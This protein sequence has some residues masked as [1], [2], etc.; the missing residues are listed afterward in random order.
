MDAEHGARDDRRLDRGGEERVGQPDRLDLFEG[1]FVRALLPQDHV[2][3]E[4]V[5]L[6]TLHQATNLLLRELG[7]DVEQC[8]RVERAVPE[9]LE[10]VGRGRGADEVI[11]TPSPR[12]DATLPVA[13]E[14]AAGFGDDVH[15][16]YG[17]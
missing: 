14:D 6:S 4:T 1:D 17:H 2:W 3:D 11:T 10:R 12:R 5:G 8:D 9:P 13:F 7:I 16:F 15:L